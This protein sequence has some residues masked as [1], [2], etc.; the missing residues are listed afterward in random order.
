M[1]FRQY[2][3]VDL[4][5]FHNFAKEHE[6]LNNLELLKIYNIIYTELTQEQKL[7]NIKRF[8]RDTDLFFNE[9]R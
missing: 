8:F 6:S 1:A 3:L 2:S 9:E 7:E 5:R 4:I